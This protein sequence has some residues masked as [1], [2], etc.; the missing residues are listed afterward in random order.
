MAAGDGA[1]AEGVA[2]EASVNDGAAGESAAGGKQRKPRG[3]KGDKQQAGADKKK[4][5]KRM[6]PRQRRRRWLV[7]VLKPLAGK[8]VPPHRLTGFQK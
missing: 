3:K 7:S 1:Q 5:E 4:V 2:G 6:S 8:T